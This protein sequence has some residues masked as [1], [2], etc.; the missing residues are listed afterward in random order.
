VA[1]ILC[2]LRRVVL[3]FDDLAVYRMLVYYLKFETITRCGASHLVSECENKEVS[4]N[5][6]FL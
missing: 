5:K 2:G 3:L 4:D 1:A 6:Q